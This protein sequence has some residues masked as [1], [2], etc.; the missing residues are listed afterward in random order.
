MLKWIV[1]VA[2]WLPVVKVFLPLHSGYLQEYKKTYKS[3]CFIDWPGEF[4]YLFIRVTNYIDS[5]WK[6]RES[7]IWMFDFCSCCCSCCGGTFSTQWPLALLIL[8]K[9]KETKY[10][11][12]SVSFHPITSF[13]TTSFVHHANT[14]WFQIPWTENEE[15]FPAWRDGRTGYPWIDAIMIQVCP[16]K[17]IASLPNNV[18]CFRLCSTFCY[19]H[20]H[21]L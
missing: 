20:L 7:N 3:T 4:I 17:S 15:L 1:I 2:V 5:L 9:W 16:H 6:E 13:A 21:H 12:R 14:L 11:N 10:A 18:P 19:F 8:I